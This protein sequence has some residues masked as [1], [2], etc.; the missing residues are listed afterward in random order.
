LRYF[1]DAE[2]DLMRPSGGLGENQTYFQSERRS[3]EGSLRL[4]WHGD[5]FWRHGP[6]FEYSRICPDKIRAEPKTSAMNHP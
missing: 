5:L 6:H 2:E 1:T 4:S 3:R